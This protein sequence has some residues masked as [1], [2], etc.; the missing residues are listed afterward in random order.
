MKLRLYIGL[1]TFKNRK[2]CWRILYLETNEIMFIADLN[3][4][5]VAD[6]FGKFHETAE[7]VLP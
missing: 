4:H 5:I 3:E 7:T 6:V 1:K 2:Y